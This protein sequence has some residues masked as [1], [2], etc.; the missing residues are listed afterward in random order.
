MN[1][2]EVELKL[3]EKWKYARWVEDTSDD[4]S[5]NFEDII[6]IIG[7]PVA[8]AV[9][10][11][12]D[13]LLSAFLWFLLTGFI[14]VVAFQILVYMSGANNYKPS[15]GFTFEDHDKFK[16][17]IEYAI[18]K[19]FLKTGERYNKEWNHGKSH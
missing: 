17:D 7:F 1:L 3:A 14:I 5:S 16:E 2:H 12:T 4:R 15:I 10:I 8:L 9:W 13:S 19:H 11:Y 6:G 18:I